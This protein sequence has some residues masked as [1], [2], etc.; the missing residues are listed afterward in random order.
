MVKYLINVFIT[1]IGNNSDYLDIVKM[2]EKLQNDQKVD[3]Y[4]IKNFYTLHLKSVSKGFTLELFNNEAIKVSNR[5]I[6][7]EL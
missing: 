1:G 3:L 5:G 4:F 2:K 7:L 6:N